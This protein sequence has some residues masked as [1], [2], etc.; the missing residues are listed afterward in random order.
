MEKQEGTGI[1][2]LKLNTNK[3]G[4]EYKVIDKFG[5]FQMLGIRGDLEIYNYNNL[6]TINYETDNDTNK[7]NSLKIS[8]C[9][10]LKEIYCSDNQLTSITIDEVSGKNLKIINCKN[11]QITDLNSLLAVCDPEKLEH[12]DLSN[13]PLR[14]VNKNLLKNFNLGRLE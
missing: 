10:D 9:P 3:I 1:K 5:D 2:A 12:L 13:N 7:L 6:K 8:N 4:Y 11:N 14:N